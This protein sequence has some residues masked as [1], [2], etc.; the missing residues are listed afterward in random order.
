MKKIAGLS[1]LLVALAL[2]VQ[3][4]VVNV[5][6]E[7]DPYNIPTFWQ[8]TPEGPATAYQTGDTIVAE[9]AFG[10]SYITI[11]DDD[12][13]N[14]ITPWLLAENS[15]THTIGNASLAYR[16]LGGN[17]IDL[18][19]TLA[20]DTSCC[21]HLGG[22]KWEDFLAAGASITLQSFVAT[23]DVLSVQ[24]E[25]LITG[26]Y[27]S[28]S[29]VHVTDVGELDTVKMPVPSTLALVGIGLFGSAVASRR[30]RKA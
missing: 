22:Y 2:P 25:Q 13:S 4:G 24:N 27:F 6:F 5:D 21:W 10:G 19:F 1:S 7:L 8:N 11:A 15:S 29:G 12:G 28:L 26:R 9:F 16:D 30:K 23:F 20:S 3:A 17:L 18:D 14:W